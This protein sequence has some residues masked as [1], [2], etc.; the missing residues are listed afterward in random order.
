MSAPDPSTVKVPLES[1]TSR[2]IRYQTFGDVS[3]S[4][5]I[6]EASRRDA[7]RRR[8]E[9]V[10][11]HVVMEIDPPGQRGRRQRAL[12]RVRPG[13]REVDR[14][15]GVVVGRRRRG[16]DR[17]RGRLVRRDAQY[18]LGARGAARAVRDLAAELLSVV[19]QR[20]GC[21]RVRGQVRARDVHVVLLPL[22]ESGSAHRPRSR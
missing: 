12:G 6:D 19:G 11:V 16:R 17:R 8:N 14:V 7:A 1:T 21:D 22:V 5:G 3:P 20:D 18:R 4:V 9:R 10:E 2:W 13:A 15:A